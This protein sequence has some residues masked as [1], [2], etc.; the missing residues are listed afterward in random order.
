MDET[1]YEKTCDEYTRQSLQRTKYFMDSRLDHEMCNIITGILKFES[2]PH[3]PVM[4]LNLLMKH[5]KGHANPNKLCGFYVFPDTPQQT[6]VTN[7]YE[8]VDFIR[9]GGFSRCG[10]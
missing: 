3:A 8:A 10:I 9:A 1:L 2:I 6:I 4:D 7:F 5:S